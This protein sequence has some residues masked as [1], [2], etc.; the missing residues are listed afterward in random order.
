MQQSVYWK[1]TN[2]A[3]SNVSMFT[4]AFWDVFHKF[5]IV[6][7]NTT[8]AGLQFAYTVQPDESQL[9]LTP[10]PSYGGYPNWPL[11]LTESICYITI[12]NKKI[13]SNFQQD[14]DIP[15]AIY[16]CDGDD[17]ML[18]Y[19]AVCLACLTEWSMDLC[20][21]SFGHFIYSVEQILNSHIKC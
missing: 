6:S 10:P 14:R 7:I 21:K 11:L 5:V 9:L 16:F 12:W 8:F 4:E 18:R 13:I 2:K 19:Q 20:V 17:V 3:N 15:I 1:T